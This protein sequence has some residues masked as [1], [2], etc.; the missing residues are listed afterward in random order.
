MCTAA[1]VPNE[2]MSA[3]DDKPSHRNH[4]DNNYHPNDVYASKMAVVYAI[5]MHNTNV[6][7]WQSKVRHER[8][9]KGS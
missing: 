3:H 2:T 6:G 4:Q 8:R 1:V 7:T 5:V 9:C